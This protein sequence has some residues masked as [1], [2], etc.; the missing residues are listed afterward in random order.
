M[1]VASKS[2]ATKTIRITPAVVSVSVIRGVESVRIAMSIFAL[3]PAVFAKPD[4][5]IAIALPRLTF[6]AWIRQTEES[7]I[8]IA[9]QLVSTGEYSATISRVVVALS[10]ITVLSV[11][12]NGVAIRNGEAFR[13]TSPIASTVELQSPMSTS[14][15]ASALTASMLVFSATKTCASSPIAETEPMCRHVFAR[16]AL[17]VIR[18]KWILVLR[19]DRC[20]C[21]PD[22][23]N[24]IW[25][26]F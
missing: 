23:A 26:G 1:I 18:A 20:L 5:P 6:Y 12:S 17:P 3:L 22:S 21:S 16:G 19:V 4:S 15:A 25:D 10:L 9:P 8:A 7:P 2:S 11:K 13:A 14:Q 24:A